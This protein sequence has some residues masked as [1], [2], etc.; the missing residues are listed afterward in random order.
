MVR[1]RRVA[2]FFAMVLYT[3]RHK[4]GNAFRGGIGPTKAY[5]KSDPCGL[6]TPR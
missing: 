5:W 6:S 2:L 1:M 3:L 4:E